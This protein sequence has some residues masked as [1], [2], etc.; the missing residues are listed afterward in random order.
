VASQLRKLFPKSR[1]ILSTASTH[2]GMYG[3]GQ[4]AA[5][6]PITPWTGLQLALAKSPGELARVS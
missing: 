4:F 2:V 5:A 1:F 6:K 3:Q